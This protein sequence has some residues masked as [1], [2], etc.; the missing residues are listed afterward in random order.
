MMTLTRLV[1]MM[2]VTGVLACMVSLPGAAGVQPPCRWRWWRRLRRAAG[3]PYRNRKK[4]RTGDRCE[5]RGRTGLQGDSA[6]IRSAPKFN[7]T[8]FC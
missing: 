2:I 5:Q 6:W 8:W 3:L 7:L 1:Q 4:V